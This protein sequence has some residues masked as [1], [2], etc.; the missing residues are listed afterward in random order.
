MLSQKR[1]ARYRRRHEGATFSQ[2]DGSR[3]SGP[4]SFASVGQAGWMGKST[5]TK[6][7]AKAASSTGS[8]KTAFQA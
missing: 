4:T 8:E 3:D 1:R 6:S 7:V 2:G 5:V